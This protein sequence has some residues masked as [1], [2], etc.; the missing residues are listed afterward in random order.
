MVASSRPVF[1][2]AALVSAALLPSAAQAQN[3]IKDR[4]P[5]LWENTTCMEYV[6]RSTNPVYAFTYGIPKEDPS[7]GEDLL[8]DE[9]EDSR[10]HQFFA[11]CRQQNSQVWPETWISQPDIDAAMAKNLI[12]EGTVTPDEVMET[13]PDWAGCWTRITEDE[14]RLPISFESVDAG[15]QWDTSGVE[16]GVYT[17]WGYTWEPAFN[18]WSPRTGSV[19]KV[20]D[21]GDPAEI[22]PAAAITSSEIIIF[23]DEVAVIEGCAD[24]LPGTTLT[25]YFASTVDANGQD[26]TPTWVP[27]AEDVALEGP[28]FA[29]ELT[30]PEE[31]AGQTLLIRID[32]TDPQGRTYE[33]HMVE[34]VS[35]LG[36]QASGNCEDTGA[37]FVGNASCGG[38]GDTSGET[39]DTEGDDDAGE[40]STTGPSGETD[41]S[42]SASASAGSAGGDGGG[43]SGGTCAVSS[44]R[45]SGGLGLMLLALLGLRRR[46]V[47]RP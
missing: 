19:V 47:F 31:V 29:L 37:S 44:Q 17:I 18:I 22:G 14:D 25:G 1:V 4:L 40:T 33:A 28:D 2:A 27:F 45:A 11:L 16:E 13:S 10:R 5:V 26:W 46:R 36:G 23:T 35:V 21:G 34:L 38:D 3:G 39:P 12:N 42:S 8:P 41:G 6:D 9:V 32:A 15:V 20:Y 24:G 43:G 30:P 7:P